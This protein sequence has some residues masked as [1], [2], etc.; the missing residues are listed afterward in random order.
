MFCILEEE[1][2]YSILFSLFVF[3]CV[4][5]FSIRCQRTPVVVELEHTL[6]V[7]ERTVLQSQSDI[8]TLKNFIEGDGDVGQSRIK[9][10]FYNRELGRCITPQERMRQYKWTTAVV[11]FHYDHFRLALNQEKEYTHIHTCVLYPTYTF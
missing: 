2:T 9:T 10:T 5:P 11:R 3:V 8:W 1:N 7:L 6:T 4:W